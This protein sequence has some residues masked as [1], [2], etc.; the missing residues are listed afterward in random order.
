M[1]PSTRVIFLSAVV[2]ETT[3]KIVVNANWCCCAI[4]IDLEEKKSFNPLSLP[5]NKNCQKMSQKEIKNLF[6][7]FALSAK[8]KM[9]AFPQKGFYSFTFWSKTHSAEIFNLQSLNYYYWLK[10]SKNM[11]M[12]S[13]IIH[14]L[15]VEKITRTYDSSKIF[16]ETHSLNTYS[17]EFHAVPKLSTKR[18]PWVWNT[19]WRL[20]KEPWSSG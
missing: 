7:V 18:S 12:S 3:L 8:T 20:P 17:S 19:S 13:Q 4:N 5:H 9:V 2:L 6:S 11:L 10:D 1:L 14:I 16:I 15:L